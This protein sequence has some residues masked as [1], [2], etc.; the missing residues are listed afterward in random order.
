MGSDQPGSSGT[1]IDQWSREIVTLEANFRLTGRR[2]GK[3]LDEAALERGLPKATG[4]TTSVASASTAALP[5]RC[6]WAWRCVHDAE[7]RYAL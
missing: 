6:L 5:T 4:S 1:V 2:V 3:V 7:I